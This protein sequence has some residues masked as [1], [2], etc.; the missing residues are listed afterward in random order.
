MKLSSCSTQRNLVD[1]NERPRAGHTSL[2][3]HPD[4]AKLF[5]LPSL[6]VKDESENPFGTHKDRKSEHVISQVLRL[7]LDSRPDAV[8]IFT[9]GN[10]GL[11]LAGFASRHDI[12]VIA[13]VDEDQIVPQSLPALRLACREVV[14][15][16]ASS[17]R[18]S[19]KDLR[20]VSG[21][22]RG[23]NVFDATNLAEAYA[24]L[25]DEM[26]EARP[27]VLVLPV[28][29]GELF[30]GMHQRIQSLG[31]ATRLVG[32]TVSRKDSLADKLY[33]AWTPYRARIRK[34][35]QH[36]SPH[37][38]VQLV[39]EKALKSTWNS[40]ARHLTCEPSSA[41]A[42]EALRMTQLGSGG[43]VAVINTGCYRSF[44]RSATGRC[45]P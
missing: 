43:C 33:A 11:S 22:A 31:W 19:E 44:P 30:L 27:D 14:S 39:D 13:I 29:S 12:P 8:C 34:L 45:A 35:C 37:R 18:W 32:V 42:F 38:V 6:W 16:D 25:V 9:S 24:G 2:R 28:G 21:E 10:A 15:I 40:V 3:E 1:T 7:P 41:A 20:L 17:R 26:A 5:G 36:P 4:L 23:K